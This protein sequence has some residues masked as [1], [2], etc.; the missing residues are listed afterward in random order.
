MYYAGQFFA[1]LIMIE[2]KD[3]NVNHI[4]S[5]RN[6]IKVHG[7]TKGCQF[8]RCLKFFEKRICFSYFL[9][10]SEE[11]QNKKTSTNSLAFGSFSWFLLCF[12]AL[13]EDLIASLKVP[14]L[15]ICLTKMPIIKFAEINTPKIMKTKKKL[16]I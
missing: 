4:N 10:Y 12:V 15:K 3:N 8:R 14:V 13:P 16:N 11:K 5:K 2:C 1:H 7:A 9:I 6:P